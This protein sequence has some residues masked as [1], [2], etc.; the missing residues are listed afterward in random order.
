M[1]K[2]LDWIDYGKGICMLLVVLTH[3]WSYYVQQGSDFINV[4]QPT[5]MFVFFF[6]SG[7]LVKV[8]TFDVRKFIKSILQKLLFPYFIFTTLIWIPKALSHGGVI[9][10]KSMIYDIGGGTQVGLWP[11]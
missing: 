7:Y 8:E 2:R 3:T 1:G 11:H 6:I 5:R 10:L 9:S 4:L